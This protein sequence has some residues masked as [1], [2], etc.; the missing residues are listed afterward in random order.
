MRST[1]CEFILSQEMSSII[2]RCR[3][4]SSFRHNLRVQQ[5]RV[6]TRSSESRCAFSSRTRYSCLSPDELK[7]RMA[8]LQKELC[9]ISKERNR[10]K[11]KI[12]QESQNLGVTVDEDMHNDLRKIMEEEEEKNP[13]RFHNSFQQIFWEQQLGAV[14]QYNAKGMRWHYLMIRWCLL[15]GHQSQSAYETLRQSGCITLPSQCTLRDY[16]HY[17]QAVTGFSNDVDKQIMEAARINSCEKY[18]K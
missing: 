9:R 6:V 18:E 3:A 10:L 16:T 13:N 1:S 5:S 14:H 12:V 7:T 17:I 4:R 11:E 15:L 2:E 8:N